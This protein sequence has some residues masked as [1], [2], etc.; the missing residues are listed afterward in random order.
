MFFLANVSLA[1]T[2]QCSPTPQIIHDGKQEP[3][4][5]NNSNDLTRH[6]GH[7]MQSKGEIIALEAIL[8]DEKCIPIYD[9]KVELWQA[10]ANGVFQYETLIDQKL[11][12]KSDKIDKNF[13]GNGVNFSDNLGEFSFLTIMPGKIAQHSPHVNLRIK[14]PE[15]QEF[16]T[17][18][19]FDGNNN[20][21]DQKLQKI[22]NRN[23]LIAKNSGIK[24]GHKTYKINIHLKGVNQHKIY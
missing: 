20:N 15:F 7:I 18:I 19:Y 13:L 12:P 24:N 14:H 5:F 2:S 11:D 9:A 4:K 17:K 16:E 3:N 22:K 8:T 1:D 6:T 21:N 23:L 10:N